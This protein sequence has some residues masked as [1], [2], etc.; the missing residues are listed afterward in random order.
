MN[1]TYEVFHV[2]VNSKRAMAASQVA[3]AIGVDRESDIGMV[4][5]RLHRYGQVSRE[6]EEIGKVN[7]GDGRKRR[8]LVY[9]Y[10][11]TGRGVGRYKV[12]KRWRKEK[13]A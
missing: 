13:E 1:L 6:R 11:V 10:R 4:L 5:L 2:L 8:H 9:F 7:L 3:K 12:I